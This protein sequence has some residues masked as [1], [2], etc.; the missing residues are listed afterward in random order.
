MQKNQTPRR[1]WIYFTF[2][3]GHKTIQTA[4]PDQ[5]LKSIFLDPACQDF[6]RLPG[7]IRLVGRNLRK[8]LQHHIPVMA[9]D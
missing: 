4:L 5:Q 1:C 9:D 7:I 6:W 8:A 3:N 2:G